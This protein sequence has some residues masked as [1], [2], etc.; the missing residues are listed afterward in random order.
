MGSAVFALFAVGF[1]GHWLVT[2]PGYEASPTQGEWP[3][4]LAFSGVILALAIVVPLFAVQT[5]RVAEL[6]AAF[7]ASGGSALSSAANVIEDGFKVEQ[8]FYMFVLGSVIP[9]S[10]SRR[11]PHC[12]RG[13]NRDAWPLSPQ[14][15]PRRSSSTSRR[16]AR[17]CW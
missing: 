16:A 17:S 6:R 8:A 2:N 14:E 4:V 12:S 5:G 15:R 13:G 10:D 1:L 9:W 11:S 7:V 3:Y